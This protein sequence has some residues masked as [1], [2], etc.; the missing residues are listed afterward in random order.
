VKA[1]LHVPP[2][3]VRSAA[4]IK[5]SLASSG[6]MQEEGRYVVRVSRDMAPAA[7]KKS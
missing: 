7:A 6:N 4:G 2:L 1:T 5:A 3:D